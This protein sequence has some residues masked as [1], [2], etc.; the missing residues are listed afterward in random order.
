[1]R[2]YYIFGASYEGVEAEYTLC[3]DIEIEGYIDN[4][5]EGTT[6]SKR[7]RIHKLSETIDDKE[8]FYIVAINESRYP[9]IKK[10]LLDKGLK[11]FDDFIYWRCFGKRMA[12]LYGNCH[13]S[14]V[15]KMLLACPEFT[16]KYGIYPFAGIHEMSSPVGAEVISNCK[17]F[18]LQ[19]VRDENQFGYEFSTSYVTSLIGKEKTTIIVPNIYGMGSILFP[20]QKNGVKHPVAADEKGLFFH[21]DTNIDKMLEEGKSFEEIRDVILLGEPY[22]REWIIEEFNNTVEKF[23][24]TQANCDIDVFDFFMEKYRDHQMFYD[25]GHPTNFLMRAIVSGI[26]EKLGITYDF[27]DDLER[28]Y[29][30]DTY[31]ELVYPCIYKALGLNWRQNLLRRHSVCKLCKRMDAEEYIREYI[32]WNKNNYN[33]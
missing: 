14:V 18:I 1:M 9:E 12:F 7:Y 24:C 29:C 13:M 25:K 8:S 5:A 10:Q 33:N 30:M 2:K 22:S 15:K 3:N 32:W 16:L 28:F 11:E 17:L 26:L 20:Q 23:R 4:F 21:A 27:G 6:G 19:N 31:E